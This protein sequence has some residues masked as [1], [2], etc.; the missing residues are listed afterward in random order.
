M[1]SKSTFL[2]EHCSKPGCGGSIHREIDRTKSDPDDNGGQIYHTQIFDRCPACDTIH[3]QSP[4]ANSPCL[5]LDTIFEQ[6]GN[7]ELNRQE[8]DEA[9]VK[10]LQQGGT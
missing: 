4:K 6:W 10:A 3:R 7:G 8:F 2:H 9:V 5:D 1:D